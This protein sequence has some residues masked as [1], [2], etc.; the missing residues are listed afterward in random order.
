MKIHKRE[1]Q[2]N[3]EK[4][5][6]KMYY[7]LFLGGMT[8]SI[9]VR[10][11]DW[12]HMRLHIDKA[13]KMTG[14]LCRLRLCK[15]AISRIWYHNLSF[16]SMR[17]GLKGSPRNNL[18]DHHNGNFLTH[19][20][21]MV[22]FNPVMNKGCKTE[23]KTLLEWKCSKWNNCTNL[24]RD[25]LRYMYTQSKVLLFYYFILDSALDICRKEQT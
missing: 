20:E 4:L 10:T 1:L 17:P 16:I 14:F 18:C 7:Q 22:Q 6:R 5:F 21:L 11:K 23:T 19:V 8:K 25:T 15:R 12:K 3:N 24:T 13:T 9:H 2:K